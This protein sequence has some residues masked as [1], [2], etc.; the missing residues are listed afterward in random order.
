MSWSDGLRISRVRGNMS[1]RS[2]V[3]DCLGLYDGGGKCVVMQLI[4][5]QNAGETAL[6]KADHALP[7]AAP[8]RRVWW[9]EVPDDV[10]F[11]ESRCRLL[12][13]LFHLFLE[14]RIRRHE[15]CSSIGKKTIQS[16]PSRVESGNGVDG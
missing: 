12:I 13:Y 16:R 2:S 4:S 8:M 6:K 3:D 14:N 11:N 10:A 7:C 1:Q 9:V 15:I 5:T